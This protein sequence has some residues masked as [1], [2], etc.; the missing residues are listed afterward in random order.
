MKI[1]NSYSFNEIE[2]DRNDLFRDSFNSIMT[3]S[4]DELK[5]RIAIVFK[6]EEGVDLGGLSRYFFF[7]FIIK[8]KVLYNILY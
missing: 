8:Y 3:K 7:Y 6:G 2:I 4:P 5:K 1:T